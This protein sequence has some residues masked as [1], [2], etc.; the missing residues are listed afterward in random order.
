MTNEP[1]IQRDGF[2]N[3]LS[4]MDSG[5]SP[6][7]LK[8][9][10]AA[11]LVNATVR[12][13]YVQTRPGFQ[14]VRLSYERADIQ[15]WIDTHNYQGGDFYVPEFGPPYA[16]ISVG[17]RI[18][19]VTLQ[20][21]VSE[22]TPYI[23]FAT[24]GAVTTAPVGSNSTVLMA[25][26]DNIWEG[27]PVKFGDGVWTVVTVYPTSLVLL[28]LTASAG[29]YYAAGTPLYASNPNSSL[30]PQTWTL[31]AEHWFVIQ[32]GQGRPILWDGSQARRTN[33]SSDPYEVPT[34]T[35][36]EYFDSI[37]RIAVAVND[38]EV[39]LGD[40][41]EGST[42]IINFT[43]EHYAEG[44]GRFSVPRQYG[45]IRS[46]KCLA[47]LDTTFGQGPLLIGTPKRILALSLP[48]NRKVW[49][50]MQTPIQ[51][52]ALIDKGPQGQNSVRS[53]NGDQFYRAS[54]GI[55]SF[56]AARRNFGDWGN[57]P[58]SSEMDR[59]LKVD[60]PSLLRYG[61][62]IESD[63][64]LLM[65]TGPVKTTGGAIYHRGISSLDFHL[66]SSMGAKMQPAYDGLW[67][68]LNVYQLLQAS[69]DDEERAYAFVRGSGAALE[70]W[71]LTKDSLFDGDGG[72]PV[73]V[74]ETRS[75]VSRS[76][77]ELKELDGFELWVDGVVGEVEIALQYRPDEYPCWFDWD[78]KVLCSKAQ[79][80]QSDDA[81]V[82]S[83][84]FEATYKTR[85]RFR[86]PPSV[87]DTADDKPSIRGYSFQFR[88]TWQG[89]CRFKKFLA[90]Y[91][92][93]V[94]RVP[95]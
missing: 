12:G 61:S 31:Q 79:E 81:C 49:G 65:T 9:N 44:G 54:D 16:V 3:L 95:E 66:L 8:V 39:A 15:D 83:S 18:F 58:V 82:A 56:V 6:L 52:V 14:P 21:D 71:H 55:R 20:G 40:A 68:G 64:R 34:G 88:L 47:N 86:R 24:S 90:K 89:R 91:R 26:T 7:L 28:N 46:L 73:S 19:K 1:N 42:S 37:G 17:G 67:T 84:K 60:A 36:M 62:A 41:A 29:V 33:T 51:T 48:A 53:V 35:C 23:G 94:E 75:L 30:R 78:T 77:T 69:V 70:L 92:T 38:H 50:N 76:E 10:Q 57:L 87:C 85:L 45:G 63:N 74:M 32:D 11:F 27:Y 80:C 4:G 59:V 13:G 72:R 5:K 43:E 2:T 25:S 22:I 93:V